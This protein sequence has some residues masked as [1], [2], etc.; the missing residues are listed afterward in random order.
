MCTAMMHP[1]PT[2]QKPILFSGKGVV[3]LLNCLITEKSHLNS[4]KGLKLKNYA[5]QLLRM[6]KEHVDRALHL[7]FMKI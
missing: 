4:K 1:E 2:K 3:R 5:S 6:R 7:N